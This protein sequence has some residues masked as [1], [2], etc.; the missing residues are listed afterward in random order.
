MNKITV[1]TNNVILIGNTVDTQDGVLISKPYSIRNTGQA[2]ELTPF[3][4]AHI[5][6]NVNEIE[7][8]KEQIITSL[9]A[10]KNDI[11]DAYLEK[12]SGI[13]IPKQEII[14]G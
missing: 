1:M 5:G 4:E 7:I 2:F 14:L 13:V 3:L 12:I 8:K 6:Q 10:E 9:E 11:L